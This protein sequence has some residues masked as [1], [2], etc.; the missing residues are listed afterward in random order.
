MEGPGQ[1]GKAGGSGSGDAAALFAVRAALHDPAGTDRERLQE[2]LRPW[3]SARALQVVRDPELASFVTTQV[4][5]DAAGALIAPGAVVPDLEAWLEALVSHTGVLLAG[6]WSRGEPL[7][8]AAAAAA[9]AASGRSRG[10]RR[11]RTWMAWAA[12]LTA[13]VAAAVAVTL[14]AIGGHPALQSPPGSSGP[15]GGLVPPIVP[16][17]P[18]GAGVRGVTTPG[19]RRH[20]SP[21]PSPPRVRTPTAAAPAAPPASPT[22][23]PSATPR[24]R[25]R[26]GSGGRAL[27]PPGGPV[28]TPARGA[29]QLQ[30][31]WGSA[32]AAR[33]VVL[34]PLGGPALCP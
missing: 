31:A 32:S 5:L 8:A 29:E 30:A 20:P 23:C 16:A 17:P 24:R 33:R 18:P 21:S 27:A 2:L 11:R 9:A 1:A 7:E 4:L 13:L 6:I 22:A 25:R 26:S 10:R 28:P 19:G 3:V 14:L 34:L 12:S 15:V